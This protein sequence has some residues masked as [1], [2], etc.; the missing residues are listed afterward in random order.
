MNDMG[1]MLAFAEQQEEVRR[2]RLVAVGTA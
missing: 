2:G 1:A